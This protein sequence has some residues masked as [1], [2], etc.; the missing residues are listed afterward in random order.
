MR[1]RH[2]VIVLVLLALVVP[3]GIA[4]LLLLVDLNGYKPTI[5]ARV[6][7]AIERDVT[8]AGDIR[9]L[10]SLHPKVRIDDVR[11]AN[12]P[13]AS[14]PELARIARLQI[15]VELLPLLIGRIEVP[16]VTVEGA[17]LLL[18]T[19]PD[20]AENWLPAPAPA[21]TGRPTAARGS[22]SSEDGTAL[23][24][25]HEIRLIG[26]H[27]EYRDGRSGRHYDLGL[28]RLDLAAT[29][30]DGPI[31]LKGKGQ[32]SGVSFRIEGTVGP[33]QALLRS[34]G[35]APLS[36]SLESSGLAVS[37]AGRIGPPEADGATDLVLSAQGPGL[38]TLAP[39]VPAD[40]IARRVLASAGPLS[41][42]AQI[43][44]PLAHPAISGIALRVVLGGIE[45]ETSGSIADVSR[46]SGV[47]LQ[48]SAA[49][50]RLGAL[51]QALPGLLSPDLPVSLEVAASGDAGDLALAGLALHV[52]D[53]DLGG[54]LRISLT[55]GRPRIDGTLRSH[56][57]DMVALRGTQAAGQGQG[58]DAGDGPERLFGHR[59]LDLGPLG[60]IDGSL[61]AHVDELVLGGPPITDVDARIDLE[62]GKLR[63]A[64]LGGGVAGGEVRG[65]LELDAGG[66][67]PRM[68]LVARG[69][70]IDLGALLAAFDAGLSAEAP[71][72][73][74]IDLE[75]AGRSPADIAGAL[76]GK[77]L[78][79]LGAGRVRV[80]LLDRLPGEATAVAAALLGG[81]RRG[82]VAFDCGVADL[83]VTGGVARVDRLFVQ[84]DR[85]TITGTGSVDLGRERPD[86][87]ITA[88]PRLKGVT[89][90]LPVHI[91]GTLGKPHV[92]V[93]A[94][95]ALK[96]LG[97]A[98]A[99]L[100]GRGQAGSGAG[101]DGCEAAS[102]GAAPGAADASPSPTR[103]GRALDLLGRQLEG[104]LGR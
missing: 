64:P 95:A 74:D 102:S 52:G 39:L 35:S 22:G 60:R 93:E 36:L 98:V 66:G 20:G 68:A 50:R 5:E 96:G 104:L 13:W 41:L 31:T 21:A 91:G 18:E 51:A 59:P 32:A 14:R 8:I 16:R 57:L 76:E 49:G 12:P 90:G 6:G 38:A 25:I 85:S 47:A 1:L 7:R 28:G 103:G 43:K 89:L 45:V 34:T 42:R 15:Q 72:A 100:A 23:P 24:A 78:L 9:V 73:L 70:G 87:T 63:M 101:A 79:R 48:L 10:W 33:L 27:V 54:D 77:A 69:D 44:G 29:R 55:G 4:A 92:E 81:D 37:L 99:G 30:L 40:G 56:R 2:V 53:S 61:E 80:D 17:D 58:Q 75:G 3:A 46:L 19:G 67:V 84:N 71:A 94:Q 97:G 82:W 62:R 26:S 83:T 86:V 65:S 88:M 11:V